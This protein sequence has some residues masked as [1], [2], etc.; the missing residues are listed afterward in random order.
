MR[1]DIQEIQVDV[2]N[3]N[4][5][6]TT[7]QFSEDL[8]DGI[9]T[10]PTIPTILAAL[11]DKIADPDSSASDI[12]EIIS[13]DPPTATKVLR[14]ANSA[15]YGLRN[16]VSTINHA[17]TMLGFNIIRN[18]VLTATIFDLSD[19]SN[20]AG[21]FNVE[22]FWRHS[23]GV[24]V[25]AKIV[26]AEA[27]PKAVNLS[28]EF[29]ICGLLHDLGKIILGEYAQER[30]EQALRLSSEK[31]IP[32]YQAEEQTMECTHAEVGGVLAKRWNLSGGI[33]T[34]IGNHHSPSKV[35]GD[36]AKYAAVTHLADILTRAKAIGN[37]GGMNP[38]LERPAW[39]ALGLINRK[40][41]MMLD[42]LDNSLALE[43]LAL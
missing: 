22:Q 1:R 5:A 13:Q 32:L 28:D 35:D 15:Y 2:N 6:M 11:N 43:E 12:A 29:F 20:I 36:Q 21:L 33:I 17:V 42:E 23:L 26:A 39:D 38:E 31:S 40:I 19:K 41:P 8:V 24:G 16:K 14:L 10:L 34:A 37:G 25:A 30:F 9:V 4:H 7:G 27:F 3:R 18:L